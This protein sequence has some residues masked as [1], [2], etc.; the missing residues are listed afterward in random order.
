MRFVA[1]SDTHNQLDKVTNWPKGDVLLHA[2]DI[3][4]QGKEDEIEK[5]N[6]DL[7]K[8]PYKKRIVIPGNH[9]WLFQKDEEKARAIMTNAMVLIDEME[10]I[11]GINIWG[12]PWQPTFHNWA[13]NLDRGDDIKVKWDLIPNETDILITHGPAYGY[14]DMVYRGPGA[15]SMSEGDFGWG[16]EHV[17]CYDLAHAILGRVKPKYHICGHIHEQYGEDSFEGITFINASTCNSRYQ[18]VNDP[19][20]FDYEDGIVYGEEEL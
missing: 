9:D 14:R 3:T 19:Y 4:F 20:V 8:T 18:P 1:I 11:D 7:G 15:A 10:V 12:S 16:G 5:F 17:G 6:E 2:G 13:F